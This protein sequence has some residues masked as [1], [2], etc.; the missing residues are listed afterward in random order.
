[1]VDAV[2]SAVESACSG[3]VSCADILALI[4]R[5]SVLL[6]SAHLWFLLFTKKNDHHLQ[7]ACSSSVINSTVEILCV[8]SLCKFSSS[9]SLVYE[10][11]DHPL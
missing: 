1:M 8:E 4:A 6:V 10:K 11:C 2:K 7:E 9:V 3:V 5:D